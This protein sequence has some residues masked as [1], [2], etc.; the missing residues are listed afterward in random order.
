M[1]SEL[2]PCKSVNKCYITDPCLVWFEEEA[3]GAGL[4]VH[5]VWCPHE[6]HEE[7]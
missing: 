1:R 7:G 2:Y 5:A 6:E 3:K 4:G